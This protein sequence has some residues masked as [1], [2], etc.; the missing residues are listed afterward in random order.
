MNILA[1]HVCL[2]DIF[3]NYLIFNISYNIEPL[4]MSCIGIIGYRGVELKSPVYLLI[5]MFLHTIIS[6]IRILKFLVIV[7]ENQKISYFLP[8][9]II[10]QTCITMYMIKYTSTL[11][12]IN[13]DFNEIII[14]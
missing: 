11:K 4:T 2:F 10:Y 6:F 9:S 1:S 7:N 14:T 5:Y 12:S 3:I 8:I 13:N